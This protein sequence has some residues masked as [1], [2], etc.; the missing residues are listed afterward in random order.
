MDV[1]GLV[2]VI[3]VTFVCGDVE[4]TVI[5]PLGCVFNDVAFGCVV[6][7]VLGTVVFAGVEVVPTNGEV[8][9]WVVVEVVVVLKI[10]SVKRKMQRIRI[11]LSK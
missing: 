1:F 10:S 2:G 9:E 5:K 11:N 6:D 8:G 4:E 3:L 7:C